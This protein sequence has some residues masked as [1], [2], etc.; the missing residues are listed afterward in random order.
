MFTINL[1]ITTFQYTTIVKLQYNKGFVDDIT[2]ISQ[3]IH[4]KIIVI[5]GEIEPHRHEKSTWLKVYKETDL[6]WGSKYT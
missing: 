6:T 3:Y 1:A 4:F 2:N 5:H